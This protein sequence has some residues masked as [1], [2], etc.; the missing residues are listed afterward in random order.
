MLYDTDIYQNI[1]LTLY[2]YLQRSVKKMPRS[3]KWE[4][5]V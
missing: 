1:V 4:N 3:I 5:V 2:D